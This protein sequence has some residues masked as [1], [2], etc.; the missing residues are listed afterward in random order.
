MNTDQEIGIN[1]KNRQSNIELYRIVLMLL[2]IASHYVSQSGLLAPNGP[3]YANPISSASLFL[4]ILGAWGRIAVNGFVLI[5]GYFM[6]QKT[7]KYE[8]LA[9]LFFEMMFYRIVISIVLWTSGYASISL[10]ELFNVLIPIRVISDGFIS[11]YL[12]FYLF[13]PYL[14]ILVN[15]LNKKMHFLLIMLCLFTYTFFGTFKPVFVVVMNKVSWFCVVYFIGAYLYKYPQ[16]Y[17]NNNKKKVGKLMLASIALCIISV[18][19][20][21]YISEKYSIQFAYN[22]NCSI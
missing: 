7:A 13:I 15:C 6:C 17:T 20:G 4:L 22:W 8:K 12:V 9:S 3:I 19:C 14:N 11:E 16:L 18:I 21:A 1:T 10:Q 2:I 5:T